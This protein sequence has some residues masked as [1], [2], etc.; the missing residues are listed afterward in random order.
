MMKNIFG[1]ILLTFS[2]TVFADV[3]I[4]IK[5][6][7]V[8]PLKNQVKNSNFADGLKHWQ[9]LQG[10]QAGV[11][12]GIL[13]IKGDNK[14]KSG[15]YQPIRFKEP[16]SAGSKIFISVETSSK[17][18]DNELERPAIIIYGIYKDGT[19]SYL[20]GP[21]L[22]REQ[23]EWV[24][25]SKT[26]TV[27]KDILGF[28][29]YIAYYKQSGSLSVRSVIVKSCKGEIKIQADGKF[30]NVKVYNS[31]EGL[32]DNANSSAYDKKFSIIPDSVYYVEVLADD[33]SIYKKR[34]PENTFV[35]KS[36]EKNA[37][38]V[39]N[40]FDKAV[41]MPKSTESFYFSMSYLKKEAIL[42]F[43]ARLASKQTNKVS[44][45]THALKLT[46]NGKKITPSMLVERTKSF[47]RMDG[48]I[49][50]I[51]G[52]AFVIFYSPWSYTLG[53]YNSYCPVNEINRNPFLYKF[54]VSKLIKK[55]RNTLEIHNSVVKK[56]PPTKL[57]INNAQIL[58]K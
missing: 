33:G 36:A 6:S 40:R 11:S 10:T 20:S 53:E 17:D 52:S 16:V 19:N 13:T 32:I 37:I 50:K 12:N 29:L 18:T 26:I 57:Y 3:K 54:D 49:T 41:I 4:Q 34:Y 24:K 47:T 28:N 55:G 1:V 46:L 2:I 42:V 56:D 58:I 38:P 9:I 7:P 31:T 14:V 30:K 21:F 43:D 44:G 48:V 27:K 15:L 45:Y 25:S 23:H 5:S 39:F 8:L 22:P 35:P 51:Y